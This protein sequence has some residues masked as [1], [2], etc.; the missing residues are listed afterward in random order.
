MHP[1]AELAN[2]TKTLPERDISP[3]VWNKMHRVE[4]HSFTPN[5]LD[6]DR[7]IQHIVWVMLFYF[8]LDLQREAT[9]DSPEKL[10][11]GSDLT[12]LGGGENYKTLKEELTRSHPDCSH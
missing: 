4:K 3:L 8:F 1:S 6:M 10:S 2:T 9:A 11:K 5:I 7:S 12:L